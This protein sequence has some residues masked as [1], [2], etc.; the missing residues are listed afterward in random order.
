[1]QR[2][3]A[4]R[5]SLE[6]WEQLSR[7]VADVEALAELIAEAGDEQPDLEAELDQVLSQPRR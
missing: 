6:P 5:E 3:S 2:I 7:Q 1:M 4:L